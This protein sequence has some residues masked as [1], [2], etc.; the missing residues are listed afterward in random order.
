MHRFLRLLQLCL[1]AACLAAAAAPRSAADP[2]A[3]SSAK[4]THLVMQLDAPSLAARQEAE[5]T[6]VQIG[7]PALP[8]LAKARQ[9]DNI[10]VRLRAA[11]I[12]AKI[13]EQRIAQADVHAVG[14]YEAGAE[15]GRVVVRIESSP[16]PVVLIVCAW[17]TVQWDVQLGQGV[18]LIKVIASGHH[19]Q[20]VLGTDAGV[21]SLSTEGDVPPEVRDKAFFAYLRPSLGYDL[22]CQRIKELTGKEI[23]SFQCRYEGAGKPFVIGAAK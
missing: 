14:I 5:E 8:A 7:V 22:M 16:R 2:P 6:L 20:K 3:E 18:E 13:N 4:I 19:P 17:E 1:L 21:Q 11:A 23:S 15:D 10:E 9:S 12:A